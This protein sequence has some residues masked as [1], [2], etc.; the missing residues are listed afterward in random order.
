MPI[1]VLAI[2]LTNSLARNSFTR[3]WLDKG[4]Q[5]CISKLPPELPGVT[6]KC[7]LKRHLETV[8]I[9]WG[10]GGE[11]LGRTGP[12]LPWLWEASHLPVLRLEP[13]TEQTKD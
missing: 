11:G 13:P 2:S 8:R 1:I 4:Y 7:R 9:T 10:P 5:F 6:E 12:R 3:S